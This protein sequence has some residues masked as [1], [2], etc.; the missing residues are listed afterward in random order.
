MS[1]CLPILVMGTLVMVRS[2]PIL[3]L[4]ISL[5]P[6]CSHLRHCPASLLCGTVTV[7]SSLTGS[8]RRLPPS[9]SS[10]AL[11]TSTA[12]AQ[13]SSL[14]ILSPPLSSQ[15]RL[16][17]ALL[18]LTPSWNL[19]PQHPPLYP[20]LPRGGLRRTRSNHANSRDP[21][22]RRRRSRYG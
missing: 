22:G 21:P 16:R 20:I 14:A 19:L 12:G 18:A 8:N 4:P 10:P 6:L 13:A 17:L 11:W 2:L 9:P 3:V 1:T 5:S 15:A 7:G